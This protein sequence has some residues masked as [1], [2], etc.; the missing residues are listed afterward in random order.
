MMKKD[1]YPSKQPLTSKI[2]KKGDVPPCVKKGNQ[3]RGCFGWHNMIRAAETNPNWRCY[4][5]SCEITGLTVK[6]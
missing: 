5:L 6:F 3:C 1:I 2:I 4:P